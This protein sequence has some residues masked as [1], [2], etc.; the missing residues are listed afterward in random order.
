MTLIVGSGTLTRI[1]I[2]IQKIGYY[3]NKYF[4]ISTYL[5]LWL[6]TY[7]SYSMGNSTK[8]PNFKK[9][10]EKNRNFNANNFSGIFYNIQ[11]YSV[12]H[13]YS[14]RS[15]GERRPKQCEALLQTKEI[16]WSW[17]N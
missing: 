6:C 2:I 14:G 5:L 9:K 12:D 3:K 15:P 7:Q 16:P 1:K 17:L 11:I 8:K 13:S 4:M 10:I